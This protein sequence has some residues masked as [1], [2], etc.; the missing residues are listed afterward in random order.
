MK[1]TYDYQLKADDKGVQYLESGPETITCNFI[2]FH[3]E[4]NKGFTGA[5]ENGTNDIFTGSC[6]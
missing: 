4:T 2:T 6:G 5:T 3:A 1:L